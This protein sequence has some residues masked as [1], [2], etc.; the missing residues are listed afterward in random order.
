M[1]TTRYL[2]KTIRTKDSF[3]VSGDIGFV[4][5]VFGDKK[6]GL[7]HIIDRRFE[8]RMLRTTIYRGNRCCTD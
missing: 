4:E 2:S 3:A 8:E 5:I 1:P 6:Y 7:R